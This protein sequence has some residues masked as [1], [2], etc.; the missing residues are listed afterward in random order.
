MGGLLLRWNSLGA[1]LA[2]HGIII[3]YC[4]YYCKINKGRKK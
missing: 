4:Y 2:V 1:Y 3:Y